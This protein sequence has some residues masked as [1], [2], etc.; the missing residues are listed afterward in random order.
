MHHAEL[1][2]GE[3]SFQGDQMSRPVSTITVAELPNVN[4]RVLSQE[5]ILDDQDASQRE[6]F[7]CDLTVSKVPDFQPLLLNLPSGPSLIDDWREATAERIDTID[8][9]GLMP[10]TTTIAEEGLEEEMGKSPHR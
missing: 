1:F 4:N 9:C 6:D 2:Y 5:P 8:F 7:R 10:T 3:Q